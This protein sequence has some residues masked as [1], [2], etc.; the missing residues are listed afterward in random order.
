MKRKKG[1]ADNRETKRKNG[2]AA[3]IWGEEWWKCNKKVKGARKAI[4][5]AVADGSFEAK[6]VEEMVQHGWGMA[7][8]VHCKN[9][10]HGSTWVMMDPACGFNYME[11]GVTDHPDPWDLMKE[12]LRNNC[13]GLFMRRWVT[14]PLE[15]YIEK[16]A[17]V[18]LGP[19]GQSRARKLTCPCCARP[20]LKIHTNAFW[21]GSDQ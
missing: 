17:W 7:T 13:P 19:D 5:K 4:G 20:V 15:L 14:T 8:L 12:S 1:A 21:P 16:S 6:V 10:T 11:D 2:D 9:D 18:E 3:N